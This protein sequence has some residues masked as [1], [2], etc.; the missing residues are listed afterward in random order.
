M[1]YFQDDLFPDTRVSWEP[2]LD[3]SEWFAG[4]NIPI[5]VD[6]VGNKGKS[7]VITLKR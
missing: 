2:S 6:I 7:D 4:I 5:Q 1:E 3:S